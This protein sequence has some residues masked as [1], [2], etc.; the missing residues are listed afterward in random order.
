MN[1]RY[2]WRAR[3]R[4]LFAFIGI[5]C[6]HGASALADAGDTLNFGLA[7]SRTLDD[8]V[9]R[10]A[11]TTDPNLVI[12]SSERGDTST[13]TTFSLMADKTLGRQ[14][15]KLDARLST[16]RY[17][18]FDLLNNEPSDL[19]AAWLWRFGNRLRGEL[20]ASY[21]ESLDGFDDVLIPV[22]NITT[23]ESGFGS[24]YLRIGADWETFV[25]AARNEASSSNAARPASNSRT[26]TLATGLR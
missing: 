17:E 22:R 13:T 25:S 14:R 20:S 4:G 11:P 8:N 18:R 26:Q 3:R 6:L 1:P 12:G 15:L 19:R 2:S 16:V 7:V 21:R 5:A 10:L 9:F 23:N 24:L